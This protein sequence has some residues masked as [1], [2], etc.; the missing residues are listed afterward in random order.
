MISVAVVD[1]GISNGLFGTNKIE[2]SI[3]IT[4]DLIIQYIDKSNMVR[5]NISH[6]TICAA[7]IKKYYPEAILT[8]IK[9]LNNKSHKCKKE[10]LIKAVEWC[11]HNDVQVINL[12]I[13]TINYRDFEPI[14]EII[15]KAYKRGLI[16]V[17][18]CNNKDI[19]TYPASY[20]NTIG[21]KCCKI[22]SLKEGEHIFNLYPIDG[23]EVTSCSEH[24][25][26][27]NNLKSKITSKC[28]S[29][30][31]P[32]IT[33]EVC[34]IMSKFPNIT[35]RKIKEELYKH[36]INYTNNILELNNIKSIDWIGNAALVNMNKKEEIL[37]L[38]YT[39][40]IKNFKQFNDIDIEQFDT[41][42]LFNNIIEDYEKIKPIIYKFERKQ[43]NII[44]INE[45]HQYESFEVNH[46]N[47]YVKF[48]NASVVNHFYE[49][50][51][52]KKIDVPLIIIYDYTNSKLIELLKILT[53]KFRADGY[54]AAGICTKP[55]SI[56][57]MLEYIPVSRE[58]N[59]VELKDKLEALYKVYDYDIIIL[60][61][62]I[63]IEDTDK[64]KDINVSLN[65]DKTIFLIDNLTYKVKT[66]IEEIST[67]APLIITTQGDI[68]KYVRFGYKIF[69]YKD[70]N[71]FYEYI[72][73][74]L[75]CED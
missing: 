62:S 30:A 73:K 60:G 1:D 27:K 63:Y 57:Y 48:L 50:C 18:A 7:I 6:G 67:D 4:S 15:D 33:A 26:L 16:I 25:L 24:R 71:L 12:S 72:L 43:K 47:D 51:L 45:E 65:P 14:R 19:F 31:A 5:G 35:L 42:I 68:E 28:N 49:G 20:T 69:S 61:L 53:D 32:M 17:A 46:N 54:Y 37:Q 8:S 44:V 40:K 29:Y 34:K 74:M 3:E 9:V 66:C 64:I 58:R 23:I 55:I 56:L 59:F 75:I 2:H 10:Q 39:N 38:S 52:T 36:S 13:G 21:V 41:L 11:I 70:L 22:N